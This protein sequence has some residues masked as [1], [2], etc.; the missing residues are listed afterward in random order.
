MPRFLS[1]LANPTSAKAVKHA[2]ALEMALEAQGW[3]V[4]RTGR[5]PGEPVEA[6]AERV[7]G[8]EVLVFAG[9]DGTVRFLSDI[10]I[11]TEIPIW[12]H[13][14][15]NENLFARSLGM[16]A[17]CASLLNAIEQRRI[18]FIDRFQA[19]SEAGSAS[20]LL[21]VSS[22][23][24][25]EIVDRVSRERTGAVS[26]LNYILPTIRSLLSWK[27]ARYTIEIDGVRQVDSRT[28]WV[29][30]ANSPDYGGRFDPVP[31]AV[32]DDGLID[33]CFV[34]MKGSL[35]A[36]DW[37]MHARLRSTR[38][39]GSLMR[40]RRFEH[41][42]GSHV[43]ITSE[44]EVR[45]QVDGDAYQNGKPCHEMEIAVQPRVIPVLMPAS[46]GRVGRA[47]SQ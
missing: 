23:L 29:F 26:N 35:G 43:R 7:E 42:A 13:A 15:G 4:N 46:S 32:M 27:P 9:G 25:A 11:A 14:A 38:L 21:I 34:P 22:G 5:S 12:Q 2:D 41:Y 18:H 8:S 36:L 45:W 6:V 24:D 37:M 3:T 16:K 30:V 44:E 47:I 17:S 28:G 31:R 19:G 20:G 1:I 10:A 39:R 33:T 40:S